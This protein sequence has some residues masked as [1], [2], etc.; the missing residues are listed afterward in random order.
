MSIGAQAGGC[1]WLCHRLSRRR[2]SEF[3]DVAAKVTLT[4]PDRVA[5]LTVLDNPPAGLAE[6]RG[7][8]LGEDEW[9]RR[10]GK[11]KLSRAPT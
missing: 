8:M 7:V 4:P 11:R 2:F 9:R 5:I 10:E 3:A 1:C 6:L